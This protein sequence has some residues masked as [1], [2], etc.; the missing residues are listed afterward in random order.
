MLH[1]MRTK[2]NCSGPLAKGH[3]YRFSPCGLFKIQ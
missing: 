3:S 1:S 2:K